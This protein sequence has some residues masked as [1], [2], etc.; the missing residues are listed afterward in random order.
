MHHK[1]IIKYMLH[2]YKIYEISQIIHIPHTYAENVKDCNKTQ[3]IS[4]ALPLVLLQ[5]TRQSINKIEIHWI[6]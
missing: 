1:E 2:I 5:D 3:N 4:I 6:G